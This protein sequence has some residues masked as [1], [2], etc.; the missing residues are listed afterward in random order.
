MA[1]TPRVAFSCS[2][3]SC[4]VLQVIF[5][6][7]DKDI[8]TSQVSGVVAFQLGLRDGDATARALAAW[9]AHDTTLAGFALG[10]DF[11]YMA[12]YS[13]TLSTAISWLSRTDSDL[14][15]SLCVALPY[16]A[17]AFDAAENMGTLRVLLGN[18][19]AVVRSATYACVITK[20]VF[21]GLSLLYIMIALVV[22]GVWGFAKPSGSQGSDSEVNALYEAPCMAGM[23]CC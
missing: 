6:V 18:G 9:S 17:A 3:V 13:M 4:L 2:L 10:L 16:T 15:R 20:F 23:P 1:L 11:L 8:A 19:S 21:L 14:L 5:E 7:I 22:A 12:L